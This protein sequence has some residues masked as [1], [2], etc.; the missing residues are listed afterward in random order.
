MPKAGITISLAPRRREAEAG[1]GP[2]SSGGLFPSS[3]GQNRLYF[4]RIPMT[5]E[6][7]GNPDC[8][9]HQTGK[10]GSPE[11]RRGQTQFHPHLPDNIGGRCRKDGVGGLYHRKPRGSN[12]GK[13]Y[14]C[15]QWRHGAYVADIHEQSQQ[16]D[17][18]PLEK[19]SAPLDLEKQ[20]D[21]NGHHNPGR[22]A[23]DKAAITR[24]SAVAPVADPSAAD[25]SNR[26]A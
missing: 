6:I 1:S 19:L 3:C 21:C 4:G 23:D 24:V 10:I 14:R 15:R 25:R 17:Q 2:L 22:L 11:K 13:Q 18:F 5:G 20:V 9:I 12:L 16:K 7:K 8:D 26:H